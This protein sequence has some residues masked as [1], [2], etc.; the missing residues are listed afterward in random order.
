MRTEHT[1]PTHSTI[2]TSFAMATHGIL[3]LH[4]LDAR[5][6]YLLA[7]DSY[8]KYTR[9]P[10]G[11]PAELWNIILDHLYDDKGSLLSCLLACRAWGDF[12]RYHIYEI[13][14]WSPV[15]KFDEDG[16]SKFHPFPHYV[17][18]LAISGCS[19]GN[20]VIEDLDTGWLLPLAQRLY[21]FGS[22]VHLEVD[23]VDW[24]DVIGTHAWD[25]F[26]S[27]TGFLSQIKILDLSNIPLQPFQHILDSICLF[28]S[29]EKLEYLPSH[30][31]LD[32]EILNLQSNTPSI[33]WHT[34]STEHSPLQLPTIGFWTWLSAITFTS[35]RTIRLDTVPTSD[36][37]S[38][39]NY[40][41]LLGQTL[42][43]FRIRF[44][45]PHDVFKFT[46]LNAL[47]NSTGLQQLELVGL[48]RQYP[49]DQLW[50]GEES[51]YFLDMLPGNS[52]SGLAL[53][54]D[55]TSRRIPDTISSHLPALDKVLAALTKFPQLKNI[56]LTVG[57]S[58]YDET[59]LEMGDSFAECYKKGLITTSTLTADASF[60]AKFKDAFDNQMNQ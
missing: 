54:L 46:E 45:T 12:C 2:H 14:T 13:F 1:R 19:F 8:Q 7:L 57:C 24:D 36:L 49:D 5:H 55:G 52:L 20:D 42:T 33:L 27:A 11:L 39:S 41:C 23:S 53:V 35:L 21:Q 18:H 56:H 48:I 40:L 47:A 26:I 10:C 16:W 37:P 50:A 15:H 43:D 25:T 9:L 34:F 60:L 4:T 31:E 44:I 3:D 6:Q 51:L 38:L 59:S 29:L 17:R 58:R 30:V 28:P 22:V 32:E